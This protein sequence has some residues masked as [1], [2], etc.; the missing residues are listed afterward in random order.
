VIYRFDTFE[1]DEESFCLLNLGERVPLEPKSLGVL[2]LLLKSAGKLVKKDTILETVWKDTFVEETTLTRAIA[3]IRR[4]LG[5]DSRNPRFIE[6]VPTLGYRFIAQVETGPVTAQIPPGDGDPAAESIKSEPPIVVENDPIAHPVV[7]PPQPSHGLLSRRAFVWTAGAAAVAGGGI[8]LSQSRRNRPRPA[9]MRVQIPMPLGADAADPGRLLGPPAVAP[10]G[11]AVVAALATES[12]TF[13]FIR[14]LESNQL[15]RLEGTDGG[16]EPFW[17]PDSRNI[18]FFAQSKLKR[19]PAAGGSIVVLCDAQDP[20][21]GTWGTRGVI[22]LGINLQGLYQVPEAGGART[23]ATQ[24]DATMQE[25]SHRNPVFLPDGDRFLYFARADDLD[26]RAIYL[27]S[28]S[29]KHPRQR[30]VVASQ[31]FALGQDPETGQ[32]YLLTLQTDKI[33]AQSFDPDRGNL[34]GTP[35]NLLDF[36]GGFSVSDT[37]VLVLRSTF[38]GGG[39]LVWRDRS[40]REL[41]QLESH[42]DYWNLDISPD[43][44]VVATLRHDSATGDFSV[45]IASLPQ[46]LFEPFSTAPHVSQLVWTR[47]GSTLYYTVARE[48]KLFRH[49]VSP[50]GVEELVRDSD[51]RGQFVLTGISPDQRYALAELDQKTP[52]A[53]IG[54]I[55]FQAD[56]KQAKWQVLPTLGAHAVYPTFSPDGRW[57]AFHAD[58]TGTMEVYLMDFPGGS[59]LHRVSIEGGQFARWRRDGKELFFIATDGSVMAAEVSTG[60]E[61]TV[62]T[63]QRLF[64]ANLALTSDAPIYDVTG[65]GQRFLLYDAGTSSTNIEMILNWPSM[66]RP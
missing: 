51:G 40:G 27:D 6:T 46:G 16:S 36:S 23:P 52:H 26:K 50:R 61:L 64:P 62:A 65:D 45:W 44:K 49:K 5:D 18:G 19:M 60:K 33:V 9:P 20:R 28:L 13:L 34:L 25:N 35:S 42:F 2:L 63:P 37:G 12:G 1:L 15:V 58:P 39:G 38:T 14:R 31:T 48:G 30:I 8:W 59:V 32:Y 53:R 17:S 21:G 43:D 24:L 55:D 22:V 10:D 11:S 56:P 4:Q 3:L 54:W 66:L 41:G 7:L 57:V 29:H 47:D